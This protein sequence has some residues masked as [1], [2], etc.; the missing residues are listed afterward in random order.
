MDYHN[1]KDFFEDLLSYGCQS[2]MVSS[3]IRYTDTHKFFDE[4]Y[5]EIQDIRDELEEQWLE[6]KIPTHTDLKNFLAWLSFEE[7]AREIYYN[8]EIDEI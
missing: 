1:P 7:K 5:D 3:M 4:H 8:L 2:W 6:V